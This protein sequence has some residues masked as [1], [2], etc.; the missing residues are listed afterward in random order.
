MTETGPGS[1]RRTGVL[2]WDVGGVLLTN[3]WDRHARAR[4]VEEFGLEGE[5]YSE[6]HELVVADFETGRIGLDHY[7]DRTVFH[8]DRDF[9]R[10]DFRDF[11]FAQSRPHDEA[12][13]L[14]RELAATGHWL[15]ATLNNESLELN[16]YR[17][18]TF[19]LKAVFSIF[20]SSCI[21]GLKK[22][23][24]F[25]YRMALRLAHETPDR[26]VFIDDRELNLE[27]AR[28]LGLRTIHH[29]GVG[30]TREELADLGVEA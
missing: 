18:D 26:C 25:I 14:V 7:L 3:G 13:A 27:C 1:T 21:V 15:M 20:V 30:E 24:E 28:L 4:A 5:E 29:R 10:A 17:I 19:G 22:P 2:F 6:R 9:S 12:L 23:D 8:R 11:M 16:R